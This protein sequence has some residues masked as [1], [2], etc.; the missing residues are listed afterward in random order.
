MVP[1]ALFAIV[2][3]RSP[4]HRLFSDDDVMVPT[5]RYIRRF[6]RRHGDNRKL[7]SAICRK[8]KQ[9]TAVNCQSATTHFVT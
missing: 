5:L 6:F 7:A 8:S 9:F 2:C 4:A 1:E 3:M